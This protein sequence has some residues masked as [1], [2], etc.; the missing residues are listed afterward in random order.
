RRPAPVGVAGVTV[1]HGLRLH[2]PFGLV[3]CL[4]R[5]DHLR[6]RLVAQPVGR[7]PA[8]RAR[9]TS[10]GSLTTLQEVSM[11]TT[12]PALRP[13]SGDVADVH[14]G[15]DGFDTVDWI[16][17][18]PWSTG[19]VGTLGSSHNGIVQLCMALLKP[20]HLVAIWPDVT[21]TNTY[22]HVCRD[23]GAMAMHTLGHLFLHGHDRQEI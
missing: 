11:T 10:A 18:Q 15:R 19:R 23:G 14:E 6:H 1:V 20:E 17:R 2:Q 22:A 21:P 4:S 12:V 16:A 9:S 7:R 3:C 13:A 5:T 8:R